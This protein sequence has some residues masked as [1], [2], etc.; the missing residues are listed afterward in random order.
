M[1]KY[2]DTL[3]PFLKVYPA[4]EQ[5]FAEPVERYARHIFPLVSIDLSTV[6]P[7]W[8]G[9]IHLV[10]TVEPEDEIVGKATHPF[11][12]YYLRENWVAFHL[13]DE[14]R[15]ELL[16]DLR[17]FYLENPPDTLPEAYG[18]H[19]QELEEHYAR[20]HAVFAEARARFAEHGVFYSQN[21]VKYNRDLS[22]EKPSTL[23]TQLGGGVGNGEWT[24]GSDPFPLDESDENNVRPLTPDGT[25]F[26]FIAKTSAYDYC[27][28]GADEIYLFFEPESRVALLTF[29]WS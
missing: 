1:L 7:S 17:Y 19:R 6:N 23:L 24:Y 8:S 22:Q 20:Q 15:Y 27:E 13:T 16:G 28:W 26:H 11:H 29:G 2:I 3:E 12:N 10:N 4:A 18:G 14:D 21:K 5:V 9:W 25:P